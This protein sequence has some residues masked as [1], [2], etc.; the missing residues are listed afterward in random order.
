MFNQKKSLFEN[1]NRLKIVTPSQWL[2][3]RVSQSFLKNKD[4]RVIHNGINTETVFFPRDL[5]TLSTKHHLNGKKVILA[6]APDIMDERKGGEWVVRL[7]E[8]FS[9]EFVF[10]LVGVKDITR[11]FPSNVIALARTDNQHQLAEYYSLAD[12]FLI[13]SKRENFPTTCLESLA[14]GTPVIGFDEGGIKETAPDN[15]GFFVSY[16]SLPDLKKAV[17]AFFEGELLLADSDE[18]RRYAAKNY[19][20]KAMFD[21]YYKLYLEDF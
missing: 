3:D 19:S 18:C 15:L 11:Q 5:T 21:S 1:F 17:E 20:K 12:L 7:A 6:V 8:S 16:G 13:C 10:I 4:I 2:A 9:D 14:C